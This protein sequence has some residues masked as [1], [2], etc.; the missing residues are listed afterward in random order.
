MVP[1]AACSLSNPA[2]RDGDNRVRILTA[3]IITFHGS[4]VAC[5]RLPL[6][7]V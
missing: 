4:T 1:S 5:N 3:Y 6:S 2:R 7:L